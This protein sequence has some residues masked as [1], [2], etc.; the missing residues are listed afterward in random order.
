MKVADITLSWDDWVCYG[1]DLAR[2]LPS[3][4]WRHL[5]DVALNKFD[6][7][8]PAGAVHD[9]D[10]D[11]ICACGEFIDVNVIFQNRLQVHDIRIDEKAFTVFHEFNIEGGSALYSVQLESPIR[12][13]VNSRHGHSALKLDSDS[14]SYFDAKMQL[15]KHH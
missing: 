15:V 6:S 7:N 13:A 5:E 2:K 9:N 11:Q 4:A 14:I 8:Q 3:K 1:N 12:T 10:V